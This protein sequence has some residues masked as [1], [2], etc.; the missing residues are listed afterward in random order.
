MG[1]KYTADITRE[2]AIELIKK[3]VLDLS[4]LSNEELSEALE[5][6]GY[7]DD[8]DLPYFGA[9]FNVVDIMEDRDGQ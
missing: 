8:V 7:G 3:K 9:N 6:L 2:K 1:W 4:S 5:G